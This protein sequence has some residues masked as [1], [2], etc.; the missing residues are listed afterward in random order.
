MSEK[1]GDAFA[2]AVVAVYLAFLANGCRLVGDYVLMW[3]FLFGWAVAMLGC[4]WH[5]PLRKEE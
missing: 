3:A 5:S 4:L 2:Y 1:N